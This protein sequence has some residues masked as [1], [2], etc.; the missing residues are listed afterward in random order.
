MGG[1][2]GRGWGEEG[3]GWGG[4]GCVKGG[5][6]RKCAEPRYRSIGSA[7][8]RIA[9]FSL[10]CD[11]RVVAVRRLRGGPFVSL[12]GC[13]ALDFVN[14]VLRIL[15]FAANNSP[16][17]FLF[18]SF[19]FSSFSFLLQVV[20]YLLVSFC[21]ALCVRSFVFRLYICPCLA[22]MTPPPPSPF[23]PTVTF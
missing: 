3:V 20:D 14:P 8:I 2:G 11:L 9:R 22:M 21:S 10:L 17:L 16:R 15:C 5:D 18:S 19:N 1:R 23:S 13:L 12:P 6:F 7:R 4:M